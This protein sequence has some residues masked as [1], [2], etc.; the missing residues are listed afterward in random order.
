MSDELSELPIKSL[1]LPTKTVA[2]LKPLAVKTIAELYAVPLPRLVELGLTAKELATLAEAA[3]DFGVRWHSAEEVAAASAQAGAEAPKEKVKP[4][5]KA[6]PAPRATAGKKVAALS[7]ADAEGLALVSRLVTARHESIGGPERWYA[8]ALVDVSRLP[9]A[10][11][12]EPRLLELSARVGALLEAHGRKPGHGSQVTGAALVFPLTAKERPKID[13]LASAHAAAIDSAPAFARPIP[14][15]FL[16]SAAAG[17]LSLGLHEEVL[18]LAPSLLALVEDLSTPAAVQVLGFLAD[19]YAATSRAKDGLEALRPK[20]APAQLR[21]VQHPAS[22][23]LMAAVVC[24]QGGDP[25]L[26]V[27]VLRHAFAADRT[28]VHLRSLRAEALEDARL[29]PLFGRDDFRALYEGFPAW[30]ARLEHAR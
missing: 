13:Q 15:V 26:A 9:E 3:P 17:L 23:L 25:A 2:K 20:L 16:P 30:L 12:L 14:R 24:V 1:E 11:P 28:P 29:A 18:A 22:P 10:E 4:V 21:H 27:S 5:P 6:K 7:A 8:I 19:A